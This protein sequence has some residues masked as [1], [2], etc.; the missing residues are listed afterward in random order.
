M[1]KS[2]VNAIGVAVTAGVLLLGILVF[3]LPLWSTANA[4]VQA[5]EGVAAQNRTQQAVLDGLTAQAAELDAV[6]REVAELRREIP[7]TPH[8]EDVVELAA[9]AALEAGATLVA[10]RPAD[11]AAFA[12]RTADV[13]AAETGTEVAPAASDPAVT[14]NAATG[15]ALTEDA[16]ADPTVETAPAAPVV[17]AADGPQ[18]LTVTVEFDAPDLATATALL[19]ALRAGPRL[20]AVTGAIVQT[21]DD[22]VSVTATMQVFFRP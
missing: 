6:E 9:N 21:D 16:T 15:D 14:E 1:S 10:V 8:A 22:A 20:V 11:A 2:L 12:P 7:T 19:D 13:V 18:Q 3:A 17:A 4:T 5:A